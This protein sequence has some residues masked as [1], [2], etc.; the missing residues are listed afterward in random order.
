[1]VA[2][3]VVLGIPAAAFSGDD[4]DLAKKLKDAYSSAADQLVG[5][6]DASGAWK[7]G[8]KGKQ[9]LSPSSTA[10]I[11]ASLAQAP[12]PV[13]TK[14]KEATAKGLAF[15]L[16]KANADGSFGEGPTGAFLKT[17]TTALCLVALS[18]VERTDKVADAIRGAQAYL[19][20][21]QL[22]EGPHEGGLGYGDAPKDKSGRG[23]LSVTGFAAEGLMASGLPQDDEFWKL[24]VKFVRK[25]QNNSE[26]NTDPEFV[27]ALKAKN[28][29]VGDDGGLYYAPVASDKASPA[30]TKKIADKE[31]IASY[32]AMT[33]DGIKT[34]IYAGLKKDSP[35][36]KAAVDWVR[37]N[38]SLD[39]HPGFV[40]EEVK[41]NHLRGIYYYYLLMARALDAY[42]ENPFV[43]FDGKKHDWPKELAEQFLKVVRDS[44]LWANDNPAWYEDDPVITSSYVLLTC[45]LLFKHLR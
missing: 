18:A 45:D 8:P 5:V 36:V 20:A 4:G 40:Y 23:D 11:V 30:G 44:K 12:E 31:V 7:M 6:Q 13:R 26:V 43:T 24:V 9:T 16:S 21:N 34:Y 38:Y 35:E 28:M 14:H 42:G 22:K 33:Y 27:A 2:L 29:A 19:K 1:M 39:T 10:L 41:R 3:L 17:Y 32:G 15:I 37:K 25:C